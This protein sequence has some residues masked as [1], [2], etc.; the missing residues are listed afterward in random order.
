MKKLGLYSLLVAAALF[1]GCSEKATEIDTAQDTNAQA[2]ANT[3]SESNLNTMPDVKEEVLNGD[4]SLVETTDAG[5]TFMVNGEKVF[6]SNVY[7]GFDRYDL[8]QKQKAIA[9]SNSA[10]IQVMNNTG[11]KISGNTDEWG[12]DEY[13]YALGLKRAKTVK[14]IMVN[15]GIDSSSISLISLGESNPVCTEKNSTCW[16]KNRRV[17]HTLVK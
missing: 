9:I 7:F 8:T 1:T 12:S 15:E 13:N 17:E 6:V 5:S 4:Y 11:V 16:Q 3:N 2:Q 14:D 10:K